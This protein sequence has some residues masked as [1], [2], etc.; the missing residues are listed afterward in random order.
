[1]TSKPWS[2]ISFWQRFER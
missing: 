2:N 1:M